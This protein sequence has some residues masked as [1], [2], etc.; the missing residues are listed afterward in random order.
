VVAL[1][2]LM[3]CLS[4]RAAAATKAGEAVII[5]PDDGRVG[6]G[7]SLSS[8]NTAT[9][10]SLKLPPSASCRGDS[11]NDGYR[12]QTYMVPASVDPA[13]LTFGSVG[14]IPT[15]TGASFRE[16]LFATT[17][18][19]V[20]N[21][22]TAAA[23]KPPGPGPIINIPA[24][25]F[26]VYKSGDVAAGTYNIGVACTRGQPSPTQ[27]DTYWNT[28]FDVK[29]GLGD[30]HS[31]A[32]TAVGKA[33][34]PATA[35]NGTAAASSGATSDPAAPHGGAAVATN[36]SRGATPRHVTSR[37]PADAEPSGAPPS[38]HLPVT[39][40][41]PHV[42]LTGTWFAVLVAAAISALV[43]GRLAAL[44][45]RR[46][47]YGGTAWLAPAR[48]AAPAVPQEGR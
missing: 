23:T 42:P 39:Q 31:T 32:W 30:G 29:A 10:F 14:P 45:I 12:V 3:T 27:L 16:P 26:A 2:P 35:S 46:N 17:S 20:V 19:P 11:A 47:R 5:T 7:R 4:S 8:G 41:L 6:A 38:F 44:N 9:P 15:G 18:D 25:N 28:R 1:V 13:T 34:P 40:L 37:R 22:Q 21:N 43:A 48:L 24:M 36:A 33:P